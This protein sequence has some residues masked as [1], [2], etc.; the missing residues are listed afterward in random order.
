MERNIK[1]LVHN[2]QAE[3]A[4]TRYQ[5]ITIDAQPIE[6]LS[7]ISFP[8]LFYNHTHCTSCRYVI[9]QASHC[10]YLQRVCVHACA[11]SYVVSV[12]CEKGSRPLSEWATMLL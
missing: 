8:S 4:D 2:H 9:M 12:S 1:N 6:F 11:Q 5:I 7:Y 10:R 3:Q